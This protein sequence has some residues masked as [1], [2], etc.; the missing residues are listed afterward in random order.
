MIILQ[1]NNISLV[2]NGAPSLSFPDMEIAKGSRLLLLGP[3]GSGK[4]TLLSILAGFLSPSSGNVLF[5]G[6]D[7]HTMNPARRDRLRGQRFGFIFQTLHL[8]PALTIRQNIALAAS[9]AD[10][11]LDESRLEQLLRS[12]GLKDKAQRRPHALS[13]G[14]LQRA[15]V[16]RAVLNNPAIIIA[17]EPTSALDDANALVVA[18]LLVEQARQTGAALLVATHDHRIAASFD[19]VVDLHAAMKEAA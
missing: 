8:L 15:A 11:P 2:R 3:S 17:D 9:M 12:L 7:I 1:T 6:Q 5:E 16:A 19:I 18:G 4:T 13:Q 10:L 14:E